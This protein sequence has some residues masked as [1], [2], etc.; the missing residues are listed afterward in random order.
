M[1]QQIHFF[2]FLLFFSL[3]S[4]AQ[5]SNTNE[6]VDLYGSEFQHYFENESPN[7][8]Q[9][10][11]EMEQTDFKRKNQNS[12]E[13]LFN[14]RAVADSV[15]ELDSVYYYNYTSAQDSSLD[16][17]YLYHRNNFGW[18]DSSVYYVW[19]INNNDWR[20]NSKTN[21]IYDERGNRTSIISEFWDL[22]TEEW[23]FNRKSELALDSLNRLT[24]IARYVWDQEDNHWRTDIKFDYFYH[25]QDTADLGLDSL[26]FY[27][28]VNDTEFE[29]EQRGI[30]EYVNDTLNVQ[31]NYI[32]EADS[33]TWNNLYRYENYLN[34]DGLLDTYLYYSYSDDWNLTSRRVYE[35]NDSGNSTSQF[36]YNWSQLDNDWVNNFKI[37]IEYNENQDIVFENSFYWDLN[38][39]EWEGSFQWIYLY[40]GEN[41]YERTNYSWDIENNEWLINSQTETIYDAFSNIHTETDF[42]ADSLLSLQIDQKRYFFY[43]QYEEF[44]QEEEEEEEEWM[45]GLENPSLD[46]SIAPNPAEDFIILQMPNNSRVNY[47]IVDFYGRKIL[48]GTVNSEI[49]SIDLNPLRSGTYLIICEM[50]GKMNQIKFIKQ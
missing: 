35:Y 37:A 48:A 30:I 28:S 7:L 5:V 38:L 21:Y 43:S 33:M 1:R 47:Q 8:F 36:T 20:Y 49:S 50:D 32:W 45:V 22:N 26:L 42:D 14:L 41:Q 34:Q 12:D 3:S 27:S 46:I 29:L 4:F 23:N 18:I 10:C 31:T 44:E 6:M 15:F 19:H 24:S 17:R 25:N 39:M 40:N 13:Q 2:L 16:F 9:L 11:S